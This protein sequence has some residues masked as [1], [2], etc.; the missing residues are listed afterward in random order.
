MLFQG[1]IRC[2]VRSLLLAEGLGPFNAQ[3]K[4]VQM[5]GI[6]PISIMVILSGVL[7]GV[8]FGYVLQRGRY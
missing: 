2:G 8:I 6:E 4:E 7:T 3:T 1:D 5:E